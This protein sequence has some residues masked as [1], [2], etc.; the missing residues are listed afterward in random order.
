MAGRH[1]PQQGADSPSALQLA[2][3]ERVVG[4]LEQTK[5]GASYLE[6]INRGYSAIEVWAQ[7]SA[8]HPDEHWSRGLPIGEEGIPYGQTHDMSCPGC[9]GT[10]YLTSP[11]S[12]HYWSS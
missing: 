3:Q 7:Y 4:M 10:P 12:E 11:R 9:Q 2:A 8:E 6:A 5:D 1:Q